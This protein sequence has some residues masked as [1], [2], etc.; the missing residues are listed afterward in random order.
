MRILGQELVSLI[1]ELTDQRC[2]EN[3]RVTEAA[4]QSRREPQDKELADQS[5]PMLSAGSTGGIF[6]GGRQFVAKCLL[7]KHMEEGHRGLI[8]FAKQ[9]PRSIPSRKEGLVAHWRVGD[10]ILGHQAKLSDLLIKEK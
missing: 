9:M 4:P 3:F 6:G 7:A 8:L 1:F 5:N 2:P 10:W